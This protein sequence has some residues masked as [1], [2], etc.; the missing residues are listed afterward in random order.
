[1]AEGFSKS[2][3]ERLLNQI[4]IV[5]VIKSKITLTKKGGNYQ[6][7]CPFHN[8]KTPSFTVSQ[9]KQR[10]HCFGCGVDGDAIT[11]VMAYNKLNFPEAITN[12]AESFHIPLEKVQLKAQKKPDEILFDILETACN[13]YQH[14]LKNHSSANLYLQN[15][16]LSPF[17]IDKFQL[18]FAPQ[19][20]DFLLSNLTQTY[21]VEDLDKA[22][23]IKQ[24]QSQKWYDRFRARI[25]FPIKNIKGKIVGFGAR[26]IASDEPKY[27]NSP[28]TELFIKN[29]LLY[30]LYEASLQKN[31]TSIIVVEGYLDVI[32]LAQAGIL[33]AVATLG[34]APNNFH[35]KQ[36]FKKVDKVIFCFDGDNAGRKAARRAMEASISELRNQKQVEFLFLPQGEDPDSLVQKSANHFKSLLKNGTKT[37]TQYLIDDIQA[38]FDLENLEGKAS[39]ITEIKPLIAQIPD[40]NLRSLVY[41]Q[42]SLISG[43]TVDTLTKK[44]KRARAKIVIN[45]DTQDN[46]VLKG[47]KILL[48]L[49]YLA[50]D[51]DLS[52][53]YGNPNDILYFL[54]QT[55]QNNIHLTNTYQILAYFFA[56][57]FYTILLNAL[58]I[59]ILVDNAEAKKEEF[60][61]IYYHLQI[62]HLNLKITALQAALKQELS[63][64]KEKELLFYLEK[65]NELEMQFY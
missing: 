21:T 5:D 15:R 63:S 25:T 60:L 53:F 14:Q 54:L 57:D 33:N 9:A 40:E 6:A 48:E 55:L 12:L 34:T 37:L 16:G 24:N 4:D 56:E 1:M 27:L 28:E 13:L 18:G 10:Y 22:G 51:I 3:V 32:S 30:G 8:E 47:V 62:Y 52:C 26:T 35:I 42:V 19:S 44:T 20:W 2:F 36:I 7:C 39:F 45:K 11:F 41:E 59:D 29:E 61:H 49:P 43:I 58:K 65:L 64:E 23:L 17:V 31:L 38:K 46:I 50:R